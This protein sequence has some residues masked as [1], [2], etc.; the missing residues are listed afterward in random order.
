MVPQPALEIT[1]VVDPAVLPTLRDVGDTDKT[2][3]PLPACTTVTVF[4]LP[5]APAA[6]TV[7]LAE[8]EEHPVF[9]V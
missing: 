9:A 6:V 8:R 4:G 5:V 7:M 3:V 2:G 1:K